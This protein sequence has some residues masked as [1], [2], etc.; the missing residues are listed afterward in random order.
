M[1][2]L[3]PRVPPS[4]VSHHEKRTHAVTELDQHTAKPLDLNPAASPRGPPSIIT[5]STGIAPFTCSIQEGQR[6]SGLGRSEIY[7]AINRGDIEARKRGVRTL[8]VVESL[9]RYLDGLPAYS[10]EN[11][12][13]RIREAIRTRRA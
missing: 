1:E 5:A 12:P 9:R 3:M 7:E 8:L 2:T 4:Q 6:L 11:P 10:P 13:P